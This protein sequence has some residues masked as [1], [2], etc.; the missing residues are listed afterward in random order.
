MHRLLIG[1]SLL[2]VCA[3]TTTPATTIPIGQ[4]QAGAPMAQIVFPDNW[5]AIRAQNMIEA[6]QLLAPYSKELATILAKTTSEM[7]WGDDFS[8]PSYTEAAILSRGEISFPTAASMQGRQA[9]CEMHFSITPTGEPENID[10]Y[11]SD[12]LFVSES[13]RYASQLRFSPAS[14]DDFPIPRPNVVQPIEFCLAN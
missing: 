12:P 3:C 13:V 11:C 10:A 9:I 5:E 4:C 6:E 14:F 8:L 1:A 7:A 2:A